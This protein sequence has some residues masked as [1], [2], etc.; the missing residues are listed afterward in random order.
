MDTKLDRL[1]SGG[2][3]QCEELLCTPHHIGYKTGYIGIDWNHFNSSVSPVV[4]II[5]MHGCAESFVARHKYLHTMGPRSGENT[6]QGGFA[7]GL[8]FGVVGSTDHHNAAPGSYGVGRTVLY[9]LDVSREGIWRAI[10][11]RMT[12]A[13][14]GGS[15]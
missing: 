9:A 12:A 1:L 15:D 11:T 7:H 5:S 2:E 3:G 13:A 4:E 10:R 6:Y 14:S 8:H